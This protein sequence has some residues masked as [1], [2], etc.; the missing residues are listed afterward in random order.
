MT[1]VHDG[2]GHELIVDG[3]PDSVFSPPGTPL[4]L[5]RFPQRSSNPVRVG[6]KRAVEELEARGGDRLGQSVGQL[7]DRSPGDLDSIRHSQRVAGRS[8]PATKARTSASSSTSP[9][10]MSCSDS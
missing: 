7:P 1:D 4:T 3:V 5:E 8:R 2:D 10:A 9:P 6:G